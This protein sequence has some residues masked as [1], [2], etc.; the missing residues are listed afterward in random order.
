MAYEKE[1][2]AAT[3]E[4]AL[5]AAKAYKDALCFVQQPSIGHPQE[6]GDGQWKVIVYYYGFD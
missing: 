1:F 3:K 5:Q 6:T 2:V 4:Q